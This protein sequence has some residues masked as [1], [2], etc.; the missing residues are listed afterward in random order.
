MDVECHI[1]ENIQQGKVNY[2][3]RYMF[4][5]YD[6]TKPIYIGTDASAVGLGAAPLQTK[7]V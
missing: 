5:I 3:R 1:P 7:V 4:K 6:K 2:K